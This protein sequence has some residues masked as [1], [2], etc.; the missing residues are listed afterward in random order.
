[1]RVYCLTLRGGRLI[2]NGFDRGQLVVR[3]RARKVPAGDSPGP[4]PIDGSL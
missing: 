2:S 4:G 3:R 1:V